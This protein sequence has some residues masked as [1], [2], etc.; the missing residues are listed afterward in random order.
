MKIVNSSS[1]AI[2]GLSRRKLITCAAGAGIA[3]STEMFS[4]GAA[5]QAAPIV[6]GLQTDLTGM[7]ASFGYWY[8]KAATA[9]VKRVNAN[10]GIAGREV[11]LA[12]ENTATKPDIGIAAV[13]KLLT[14]ENADFIIGTLHSGIA[15]GSAKLC[16]D[17][18]TLYFSCATS[19][20]MTGKLGNRYV[21]RLVTNAEM[22]AR[23][24]TSPELVKDLGKKWCI[25]YV[26]YSFGQEQRDSWRGALTRA[27]GEV[28]GEIPVPLGVSDFLPILAKIPKEAEAAVVAL[29]SA[30]AIGF[31]MQRK[32]MGMMLN[33]VGTTGLNA[34][35]APDVLKDAAGFYV[36]DNLP[37]ELKYK[38]TPANRALRQA[39]GIDESGREIGSNRWVTESYFWTAWE[40][41]NLIKRAVEQTGW[42]NKKDN[43]LAIKSLE[44]M[45]LEESEDFPEGR[46]TIRAED[47]Q[48]FLDT[49]LSRIEMD[50]GVSIV[51]KVDQAASV[52]PASVDYRKEALI[53]L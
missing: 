18:N 53:S 43:G 3:L 31:T 39:L 22:Q 42:K 48:A 50:G 30:D 28:I 46:K 52:Y 23:G 17:R 10:G 47:H 20:E 49:Y 13:E 14:R 37:R 24:A 26:D 32:S 4:R 33:V 8:H 19:N 29:F 15:V 5:A 27:G 11:K 21:F 36:P 40:Y 38:N 7:L 25:I 1:K 51:R 12:V 34:G 9:A 6:I 41:V 16:R 2:S 35:L 44:G 45:T